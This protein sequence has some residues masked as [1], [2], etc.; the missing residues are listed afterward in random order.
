MAFIHH[1]SSECGKSELDLFSVP[2]TQTAIESGHWVEF[3]PLSSLTDNGPIEF[4]VSGTPE[5]FID[6]ANTQLHI[7]A[8]ILNEDGTLL[9]E[10]AKVGPVNLFLHS[11]FSQTD[12][13]LNDTLITSSNNCYAYRAYIE[14]L[15]NFGP[16]AKDSYLSGALWYRDSPGGFNDHD[17]VKS[18]NTGFKAR[19]ARAEK[20]NTIDLLGTLHTDMVFQPKA[21]L[22]S[23]DFRLKLIRSKDSFSL[24]SDGTKYKIKIEH[25]SLFVRKVKLSNSAA[26]AIGKTIL[27]GPAKYA[28][29]KVD[30]KVLSIPSGNLS[31]NNDNVFLGPMPKRLVLGFVDNRAFNGDYTKSPW[32]FSH[33]DLDYLS[34]YFD[35][36]PIPMKPL[37]PNMSAGIYAR[38]YSTLFTGTGIMNDN[39]GNGIT[40]TDYKNGFMLFAFDLS[41]DLCE[42]DHF[43]VRRNGSIRIETHFKSGLTHTVNLIVY[44]EFE[45]IIEIDNARNV[46]LV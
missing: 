27:E 1:L 11:L 29:S 37:Q 28:I 31:S 45:N 25:A 46:M 33:Y 5:D 22:N 8:K 41:P 30:M 4:L 17:P 13:Y 44:A 21:L 14:T 18:N 15:L 38:C 43:N 3:Y 23:V 12:I 42:T 9:P 6:M 24:M 10:N 19:C 40:Y 16:A 39:R 32:N 2:P 7:K 36:R 26:L 20:S 34:I 35:N